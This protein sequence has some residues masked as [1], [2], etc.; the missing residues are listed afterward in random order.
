[1]N[2]KGNQSKNYEHK[3]R[4]GSGLATGLVLVFT[5]FFVACFIPSMIVWYFNISERYIKWYKACINLITAII[6]GKWPGDYK[7]ICVI[8]SLIILNNAY[9]DYSRYWIRMPFINILTISHLT[10][11]F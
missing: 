10:L 5:G 8:I 2:Q 3:Q 11:L 4:S 6:I 9:I 7:Y 1:M